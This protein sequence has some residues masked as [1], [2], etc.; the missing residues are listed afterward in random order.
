MNQVRARRLE[1]GL[2]QAQLA[3]AAGLSRQLVGAVEV[4]RHAPSVDAALGLART[5]G[6]T[7]EET[8]GTTPPGATLALGP[9]PAEGAPVVAA[10]VGDSLV[11]ATLPH[12]GAGSSS[13]IPADGVF[14]AGAVELLPGADPSGFVVAGCDPA[15]GLAA[16]LCPDRGPR[17]VLALQASSVTAVAS[18]R[19]G[20]LHGALVHGPS[21]HALRGGTAFHRIRIARWEVGLAAAAGRGLDLEAIATGGLLLARR[22]PGARAQQAVERALGPWGGGGSVRGPIAEGHLDA[23]RWVATGG[24]D[25]AVT[26]RPAARAFG[27]E[28]LA[29]EE[30]VVELWI[31]SRWGDT[32]GAEALGDVL[33]SREFRERVRLLDGYE[34][35]VA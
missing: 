9:A 7:V 27:L 35:A 3:A 31:D 6:T 34:L 25:A 18:L 5:L 10:R 20:R 29:L 22:E 8:F 1:L 13:W 19:S 14:R 12:S 30:H 4:G 2:T 33:G 32:P 16:A 28:F 23:A 15:L 17:R 26:M 24:A 21:G 11:Y